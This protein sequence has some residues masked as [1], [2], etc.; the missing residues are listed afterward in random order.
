MKRLSIMLTAIILAILFA[1]TSSVQVVGAASNTEYISEVK[2]FMAKEEADAKSALQSE[3]Y[4]LLDCNLNQ[5]AE[6]GVGSK[7]KK[8]TYLGYKTTTNSKEAITDLAVMNMKGGY[9]TEDYKSLMDQY[10]NGEIKPFLDNFI[11]AIKEYRTN[12]SSKNSANQTRAKAVHDMLN[13]YKDDDTGK[14]IGDLLLNET[15]YEMGDAA[16]N[17]LSDDEKKNHADLVTIFA[18]SNGQTTLMIENLITRGSDNSDSTWIDRFSGTTYDDLVNST[19]KTPTDAKQELAKLY[20][21][22]ANTIIDNSWDSFKEILEGYDEALENVESYDNT[23]YEEAAKAFFNMSDDLSDE[24]KSEISKNYFSALSNFISYKDDVL[25][26]TVYEM[27]SEIDYEDGTLL[28]F[29]LQDIDSDD[30]DITCIYP[31]VASLTSGQRSGIDFVSLKELCVMAITDEDGYG[32]I[33]DEIENVPET[34]IYD[35]VDRE[36]YDPGG[37]AVTSDAERTK[38]LSK[39]QEESKSKISGGTIALWCVTGAMACACVA[40]AIKWSSKASALSD[41]AHTID[42]N[43]DFVGRGGTY[44]LTIDGDGMM[45]RE[46]YANA[47]GYSSQEAALTTS[48]RLCQYLTV[49]LAVVTIVMAAISIWQTYEDLKAYYKVD[50]TPQP[51]Y[52]VEE[53]DIT[54][55]NKKGEKIVV[56]NQSAYYKIVQ[57]N[58][59][60]SDE[61]YENL[62]TGNDLNGDV[63]QQWLTLYAVKMEGHDPILASSLKTVTKST[64]IPSGYSTGIHIFGEDTAYNLNNTNFVWDEDAPSV[65]VYYKTDDSVSEGSAASEYGS[66]FTAGQL[67]LVGGLCFF[68]GV[69]LAAV[70]I[71][72]IR[73]RKQKKTSA[74]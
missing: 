10:I 27:L 1:V 33:G 37:V 15:K 24:E 40:S 18:Q 65:Y 22:D 53:T 23:A 7:G 6:G 21:D 16:Y 60:E 54:G 73:K 52:I 55:Y 68:V 19:G 5:D 12:Y 11:A 45:T 9:S 3:G 20:D 48:S 64:E 51:R 50:L 30:F 36:I 71:M 74:E 39:M 56:K 66:V 38:A 61:N 26:I 8:A 17:K 47:M 46:E 59:S 35:G 41:L 69:A 13:K 62:G 25:T 44:E 67:A 14:L 29:F 70:C 63:G 32:S 4:T 43:Y 57:T 31:M 2:V 28:D 42:R 58:R 72:I 34:S 49:G